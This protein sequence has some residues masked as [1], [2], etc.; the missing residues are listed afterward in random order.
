MHKR[1]SVTYH[2]S[3][4]YVL[5]HGHV[6]AFVR[7]RT[8][9]FRRVRMRSAMQANFFGVHVLTGGDEIKGETTLI[10]WDNKVTLTCNARALLKPTQHGT[11]RLVLSQTLCLA[12]RVSC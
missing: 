10:G 1:A 7:V 11:I 9:V 4:E 5:V 12:V 2:R 8:R 6:C 3:Y